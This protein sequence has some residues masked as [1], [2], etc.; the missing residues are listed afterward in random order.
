[1]LTFF[2]RAA[3]RAVERVIYRIIMAVVGIAAISYLSNI[4]TNL[5]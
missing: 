4:V 2:K 3:G 1:M 5:I